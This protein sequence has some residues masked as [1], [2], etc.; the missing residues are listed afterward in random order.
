MMAAL[1]PSGTEAGNPL[2]TNDP[3][4]PGVR[5]WEINISHNIEWVLGERNEDLP[6][7]NVNYG[8]TANNQWKISIPLRHFDPRGGDDH[9]GIGDIQLGWKYRLIEEDEHGFMASLYPQPLL[10]TGN[11]AFGIGDFRQ[12][13]RD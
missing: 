4:T 8:S 7:L 5:R 2:F 9:W 12:L 3:E 10:P 6:L 13:T 11:E 1:L